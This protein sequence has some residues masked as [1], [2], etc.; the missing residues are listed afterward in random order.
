MRTV[1]IL[2]DRIV[3]YAG[4]F[5]P[6]KLDMAA[7]VRNFAQFRDGEDAW[8][9]GR[10]VVPV[11]RFEEFEREA[12]SLLSRS[13]G[14]DDFWT[15][16]ALTAPMGD[17]GYRSDLRA[18]EAF[19][20]RHANGQHGAVV[21][22]TI[23]TKAGDAATLDRGLDAT[24]DGLFAF[25]ELPVETDCRGLI[26][27]LSGRFAAAKVRTG[28]VTPE[29]VPSVEQLARFVSACAAAD[30]PF[31]ATAGLHHPLRHQGTAATNEPGCPVH[32]FL[33]VFL[34]AIAAW[35]AKASEG[36]VAALLDERSIASF[37]FDDER[38]AFGRF[39]LG[40][41]DV[42]E[43]RERFALSFGSCSFEEPLEDL[44]S[45]QLLQTASLR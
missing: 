39:T 16:S 30:V 31:K 12:D 7:T 32:G 29:A 2:M 6:A 1:R 21:V 26:A 36:E 23:E 33:N 43:G 37:R 38:V 24:T 28:G 15:I 14:D 9:L 22:D 25:V 34:A 11:A 41:A 40:A 3:D 4:L 27:A 44:R 19:N 10:L 42:R 17:P 18:I 35:K 45:H 20:E 13:T 5:P 8:M